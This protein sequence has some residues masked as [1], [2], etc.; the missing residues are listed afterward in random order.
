MW[1]LIILTIILL[2]GYILLIENYRRWFLEVKP[3]SVPADFAPL[4]TFSIVIS[5]R[6]EEAQIGKCLQ[7]VL[8]QNYPSHLFE[9]IVVD[10]H[11]SDNT[12]VIVKKLQQK[13]SNLHIMNLEDLLQG[14]QLN[15]YKKKAIEFAIKQAK[16]DW[17]LTT[18]ADCV[19]PNNWIKTFSAFIEERQALFVAAPVKFI[20]TG[21]FI[22]ILQCLD[23]MSLQGITAA[24]VNNRFHSMCNGANLAYNKKVFFEVGGFAGIDNIASGEDMLLMYKVFLQHP[25][26]VKFLLSHEV[27]TETLPMPDWK[28]FINQRIR[29]AS[30]ADKYDDKRIFAVLACVY[31][32]NLSFLLLPFTWFW[33]PQ[34]WILWLILFVGKTF[35]ELRF[36]FPVARF[37]NEMKMLWWFPVMQPVHIWYTIIAGWLGKFGTYKW[38]GREVK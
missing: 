13:H 11:S 16:G 35:F 3:F 9:V 22:S 15:S 36:L 38:K 25:R 14:Q 12:P 18:D 30:K 2:G 31:L 24:S 23:F 17:I 26:K 5:A 37:Y 10:D 34:G 8:N 27:V 7:S 21:S 29:W 20:N 6:N 33:Y 1:P 19:I 4:L 32:F 28:S